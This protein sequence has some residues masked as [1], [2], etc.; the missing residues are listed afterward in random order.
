MCETH[1]FLWREVRS[2]WL[3]VTLNNLD[4]RDFI[5]QQVRCFHLFQSFRYLHGLSVYGLTEQTY[6]QRKI[7]GLKG[8][9]KKKRKK[10]VLCSSM[11]KKACV[12]CI[13]FCVFWSKRNSPSVRLWLNWNKQTNKQTNKHKQRKTGSTQKIGTVFDSPS[14]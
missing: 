11:S 3:H 12:F 4:W 7:C 1:V 6:R 14:Y 9:S 8:E 2:P 13:R 5:Q 10:L